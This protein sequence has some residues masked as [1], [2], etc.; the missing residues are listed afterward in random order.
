MSILTGKE[1]H[2]RIFGETEE[3][4]RLY[5]APCLDLKQETPYDKSSLD[6]R[7]GTYFILTRRTRF[8]HINPFGLEAGR[9]PKTEA[10]IETEFRNYQEELYVPFSQE[11][12]LH[13]QQFAM[14]CTLEY[15][16]FPLDVMAYLIGRSSWGRVGLVI[17]MATVVHP[18][19]TGV[20]TLELE[21][22]GDAPITLVSGCRIGQLVFHRTEDKGYANFAEAYKTTKYVAA[23]KPSFSL[24]HKDPERNAFH[25]YRLLATEASKHLD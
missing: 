22:L 8:S 25:Q 7:L 19:Y 2:R 9:D 5:V 14:G 3:E 23:T 20:L 13:P 24:I 10:E 17:A 6:V 18:G 21:N 16:R 12:V 1:I 11:I 15:F 4:N